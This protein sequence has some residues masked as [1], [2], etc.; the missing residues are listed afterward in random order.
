MCLNVQN[1]RNDMVRLTSFSMY[2]KCQTILEEAMDKIQNEINTS[3]IASKNPL[4]LTQEEFNEVQ[5]IR[6]LIAS[7]SELGAK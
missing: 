2:K 7:L 5:Q 6:N 4:Q 3:D 1:S